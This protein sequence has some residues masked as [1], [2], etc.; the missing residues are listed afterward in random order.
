MNAAGQIAL[1]AALILAAWNAG[2]FGSRWWRERGGPAPMRSWSVFAAAAPLALAW[3]SLTGATLRGDVSLAAVA[4]RVAVDAP[5]F[6]RAAAVLTSRPG[7]LLTLAFLLSLLMLTTATARPGPASRRVVR[8]VAVHSAAIALLVAFMVGAWPPFA[9]TRALAVT[10]VPS[11]LLH[12]GAALRGLFGIAAIAAGIHG[13]AWLFSARGET[14]AVDDRAGRGAIAIGIALATLSLASDQWA[15]TALAAAGDGRNA[16]GIL[17]WVILGLLAHD[18]IRALIH[19][20]PAGQRSREARMPRLLWHVGAA[21]IVMAFAAHVV[22]RR[23][24]LVLAPGQTV[25]TNDVFGRTWRFVNQ[26]ISR[27]DDRAR[28]VTAIAIEVQASGGRRLVT[29]EL[30]GYHVGTAEGMTTPISRRGVVVGAVQTSLITLESAAA[31]D[32][33]SV[34]VSFIPLA[35]LWYPGVALILIGALTG[36]R[37]NGAQAPI[38]AAAGVVSNADAAGEE[39]VR[40]WR[41]AP[42]DCPVCG[43]RPEPDARFCSNCGRPL[44]ACAQCGV[45]T[46]EP[47]ARHCARCGAALVWPAGRPNVSARSLPAAAAPAAVE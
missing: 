37:G 32:A 17:V 18:R 40:L 24:T 11:E 12:P 26:G 4:D 31:D 42:V 39:L 30:S 41:E 14:D 43:R 28:D 45:V 15:R 44:L 47:L 1:W 36:N 27:F 25:E 6:Y 8:C 33:A 23:A 13:L 2:F 34:R 35:L 19:S 29:S 22:A 5:P 10:T 7:A 16:G 46:A 21:C 38:A 20:A 9:A 3:A